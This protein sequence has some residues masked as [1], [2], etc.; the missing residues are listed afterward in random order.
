V[1]RFHLVTD[2]RVIGS[3]TFEPLATTVLDAAGAGVALHLRGPRTSG[4]RLHDLA[5]ALL[6]AA[7]AA[8]VALLVNDRV[9]V[10]LA[11]DADG[12]HLGERSIPVTEARRLLPGGRWIGASCHDPAGAALASDADF[13]IVGTIFATPSHPGRPGAGP[14]LLSGVR[15]RVDAPLLAIGGIGPQRVREVVAAGAHG[16]AVLSG[17]W[18]ADDPARAVGLYRAALADAGRPPRRRAPREEEP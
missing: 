10:A 7:R 4:R 5:T 18:G 15:E 9:D 8:G 14:A 12:A 16:V 11:A 3:G 6:P 2:D 17:V 13:L 1:P